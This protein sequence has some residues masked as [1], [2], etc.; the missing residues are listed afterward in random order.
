MEDEDNP[1]YVSAASAWEVSTK[2]RIG[3]LPLVGPL[4]HDFAGEIA[5]QGFVELAISLKDGQTAGSL[6]GNHKDPFD[7]MLIAQS[8]NH[9]LA[10]ISNE[11]VFDAYGVIR[12]W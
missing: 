4:A 5:K 3:K 8:K 12:L 6:T 10:L 2:Y 11:T 9:K 1:V 7:R